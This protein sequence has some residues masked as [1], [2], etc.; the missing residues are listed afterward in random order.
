MQD[1]KWLRL[2]S[3]REKEAGQSQRPGKPRYLRGWE[4]RVRTLREVA[5]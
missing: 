3:R 1:R 4:E 2:P 5:E